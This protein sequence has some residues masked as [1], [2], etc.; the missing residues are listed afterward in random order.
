[1]VQKKPLTN[2]I[3]F[4]LSFWLLKK[5]SLKYKKK[6]PEQKINKKSLNV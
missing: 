1:M 5:N 2:I 6:C 4:M 3:Y